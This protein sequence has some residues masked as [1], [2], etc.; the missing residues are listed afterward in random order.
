MDKGGF[1]V[2]RLSDGAVDYDHYKAVATH[3]RERARTDFMR[4]LAKRV[5]RQWE[6]CGAVLITST[7]SIRF[8][9]MPVGARRKTL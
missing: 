7:R 2:R 8:G 3:L 1:P 9:R 6:Q 5:R 4:R